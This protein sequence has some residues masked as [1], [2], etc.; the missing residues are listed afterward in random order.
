VQR[1]ADDELADVD[2]DLGGNVFGQHR[3]REL[4]GDL[5]RVAAV[6]LAHRNPGVVQRHRQRN[7][8][9]LFERLKVG[10]QGPVREW[11]QV[12]VLQDAVPRV[13]VHLNLSHRGRAPIDQ[14]VEGGDRNLQ[15]RRLHGAPVQHARN[16]I[17]VADFAGGLRAGLAR[18]GFDDGGVHDGK[19]V[20]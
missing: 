12:V 10:V 14:L 9:A 1:V 3:D 11:V 8:V 4:T 5:L 2:L 7:L 18:L 15:R 6:L 20:R 17:V 19:T 16:A 13:P